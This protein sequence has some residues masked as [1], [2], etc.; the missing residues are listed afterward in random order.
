MLTAPAVQNAKRRNKPYLC[1]AW[2]PAAFS[3]IQFQWRG[4]EHQVLGLY[5]MHQALGLMSPATKVQAF[6][7]TKY[8][9]LSQRSL[10]FGVS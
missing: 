6:G 8:A 7:A 4:D 5:T 2:M 3:L 9:Q 10:P 1:R